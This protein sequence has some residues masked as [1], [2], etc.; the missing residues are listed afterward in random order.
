M[1]WGGVGVRVPGLEGG[2]VSW[3]RVLGGYG[4]SM[5]G[6]S[7]EPARSVDLWRRGRQGDCRT[8]Y[9]MGLLC[10]LKRER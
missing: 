5:L 2:L 7:P 9:D 1:G 6:R 8:F 3:R 4:W 10:P